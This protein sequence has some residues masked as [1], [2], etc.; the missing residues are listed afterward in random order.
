MIEAAV[1]VEGIGMHQ[2]IGSYPFIELP[3]VG[4]IVNLPWPDDPDGL[5]IFTVEEVWHYSAGAPKPDF[6]GT[7]SIALLAVEI[8]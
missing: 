8:T 4:E 6:V 1:V 5:R 7:A 2:R 3:R